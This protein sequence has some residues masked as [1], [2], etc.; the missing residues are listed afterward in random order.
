MRDAES[1]Q[2]VAWSLGNSSFFLKKVVSFCRQLILAGGERHFLRNFLFETA[3][4]EPKA[5]VAGDDRILRGE[6]GA[7]KSL[8]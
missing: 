5:G 7:K 8:Q 1:G 4:T 2:N 6:D 3:K